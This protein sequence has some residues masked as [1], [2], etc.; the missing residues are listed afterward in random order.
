MAYD[1]AVIGGGLIGMIT[2][3]TLQIAGLKVALLEKNRLGEEASGAAAGILA[4]FHPWRQHEA[5][6]ALIEASQD[7]FPAL[8]EELREETGIDPGLVHCGMLVADTEEQSQALAWAKKHAT[9]IEAIDQEQL[10]VLEPNLARTL[11][12]ALLIPSTMQIQPRQ[13]MKA[14]RKSLTRLGVE[15]LEGTEVT[16]LERQAGKVI[17]ANTDQGTVSA[18][19]IVICNGAWAQ[20]LLKTLTDICTDIVPVRGQI[21]MFKARRHVLSH[22]LVQDEQYMVPW[23]ERHVLCGS[24]ME[25]VGFD[26]SVTEAAKNAICT[27]AYRFCPLLEDAELADQWSGLR[28]GTLRDAPYICRHPEYENL[29]VNTG[30]FRSGI[31]M[32]VSSADLMCRLMTDPAAALQMAPYG[33]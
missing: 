9:Q 6:G 10:R 20:Q 7:A 2:A 3:R 17:G 14:I 28:P 24:S 12:A 30:H 8:A 15:I 19:K 4:S 5:A 26:R 18:H 23:G 29:Y 16:G 11:D 31:A 21:L 33:C 1:A 27:W 22:I 32:S 25:Y 13:F